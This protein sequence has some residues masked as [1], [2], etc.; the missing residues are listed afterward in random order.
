MS[1]S[2]EARRR[3]G[4]KTGA[5]KRRKLLEADWDSLSIWSMRR[6]VKLEQAG[7]CLFCNIDEWRGKPLHL[8]LD[9]IDGDRKNNTRENLRS[10]CPNCHSQTDTYGGRNKGKNKERKR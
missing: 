3:G 8:Q 10:L 2:A 4:L 7:K 5:L 9:H 6:R 1:F